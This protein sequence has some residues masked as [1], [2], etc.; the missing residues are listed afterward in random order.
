MLSSMYFLNILFIVV[1]WSLR[2]VPHSQW[3]S[4]YVTVLIL[5][6]NKCHLYFLYEEC[7]QNS[8]GIHEHTFFSLFICNKYTDILF[9]YRNLSNVEEIGTCSYINYV[10]TMTTLYIQQ[11][12]VN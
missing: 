1:K 11:V 12:R 3:E 5:S 10:I 9:S 8:T 2:C 7:F 4:S 6:F